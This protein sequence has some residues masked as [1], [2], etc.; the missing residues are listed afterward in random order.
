MK[1]DWNKL[2]TAIHANIEDIRAL[3]K[4]M[5]RSYYHPSGAMYSA[6]KDHKYEATR[7]Y[8]I[9][10]HA[11][12]RIHRKGWTLEQQA[13]WLGRSAESFALKEEAAA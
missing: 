13:E 2:K 9:A 1:M 6:L 8:S 11:R 4:E 10:A 12:G 3:K 5:R 7:L